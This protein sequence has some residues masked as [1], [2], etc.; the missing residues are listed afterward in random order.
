MQLLLF[1]HVQVFRVSFGWE[2]FDRSEWW[3]I[4]KKIWIRILVGSIHGV[5]LGHTVTCLVNSDRLSDNSRLSLWG[6]LSSSQARRLFFFLF[7]IDP[8]LPEISDLIEV[9]WLRPLGGKGYLHWCF[10]CHKS[11]V[12]R[13]ETLLCFEALSVKDSEAE[14]QVGYLAIIVVSLSFQL[15]ILLSDCV[16]FGLLGWLFG[17]WCSGVCC[18]FLAWGCLNLR[19]GL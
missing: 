14:L 4:K 11:A 5:D 12:L 10:L 13:L 6:D 7:F 15:G 9:G 1:L 3:I 2:W 8:F 16:K 17:G 19:A 18:C